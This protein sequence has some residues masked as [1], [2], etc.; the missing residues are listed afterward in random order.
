MSPLGGTHIRKEHKNFHKR[1]SK[2]IFIK[3]KKNTILTETFKK[4]TLEFFN[5]NSTI[6]F[7]TKFIRDRTQTN[8]CVIDN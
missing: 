1:Y 8:K 5:K 3:L 7:S 2:R 6:L 4:H